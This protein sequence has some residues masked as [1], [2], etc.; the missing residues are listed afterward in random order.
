MYAYTCNTTQHNTA[1]HT[2][3]FGAPKH[4]RVEGEVAPEPDKVEELV[5]EGQADDAAALPVEE[6]LG[7]EGERPGVD[8][9]ICSGT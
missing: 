6:D 8:C 7:V 4:G 9:A 2:T 3:Y 5:V 1:Q